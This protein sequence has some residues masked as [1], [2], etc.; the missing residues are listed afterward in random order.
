VP[1]WLQQTG[2][3]IQVTDYELHAAIRIIS[4]GE[5]DPEH[6]PAFMDACIKR[7]RLMA[8]VMTYLAELHRR[9]AYHLMAGERETASPEAL[10]AFRHS[11]A[12]GCRA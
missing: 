5:M 8:R 11:R 10:A 4:K 3:Q 9:T 12:R 2:Q 7:D 6:I 1:H